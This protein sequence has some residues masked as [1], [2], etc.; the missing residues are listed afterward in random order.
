MKSINNSEYKNTYNSI[1]VGLVYLQF[2]CAMV[3]LFLGYTNRQPSLSLLCCN[4]VFLIFLFGAGLVI[5]GQK[6]E[7]TKKIEGYFS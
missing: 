5:V 2:L 4:S 7:L 3:I 6:L 1:P